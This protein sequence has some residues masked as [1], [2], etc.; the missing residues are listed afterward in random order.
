MHGEEISVIMYVMYIK[1]RKKDLV[2][3]IKYGV[4]IKE[5]LFTLQTKIRFYF[6]PNHS[7]CLIYI[8]INI[9]I[10]EDKVTDIYL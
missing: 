6:Y 2:S 5:L 4:C 1:K 3:V 8:P 7:S 9:E 10:F